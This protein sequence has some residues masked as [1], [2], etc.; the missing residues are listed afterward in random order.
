MT[1]ANIWFTL[2]LLALIPGSILYAL[3]YLPETPKRVQ[4]RKP[5]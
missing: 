1:D 4:L 2:I 3:K 5:D